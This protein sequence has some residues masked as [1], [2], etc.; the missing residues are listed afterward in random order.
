[1]RRPSRERPSAIAF[2]RGELRWMATGAV[3]LVVLF[4]LISRLRQP[5]A[6]NWFF[7]GKEPSAA[8]SNEERPNEKTPA[9]PAGP[10]DED[11]EEK[12]TFQEDSQAI[13][14]GTL[15]LDRVEM[16]AYDRLVAW[17]QN[18]S[19]AQLDRRAAKGLWYT[20][21]YDSPQ[22]H[23]GRP[24]ALNLDL[25]RARDEGTSRTG[26]RLH[27]VWGRNRESGSRLYD[28]IVVD[29]PKG[30]PEGFDIRVAARFAGYFL[31]LQGYESGK[32]KS[33]RAPLLIGRLEWTPPAAP[34]DSDAAM[35]WIFAAVAVAIVGLVLA[36][37]FVLR[38]RPDA[39]RVSVLTPPAD[40]AAL[41]DRWLEQSANNLD[42]A[43][44]VVDHS[45]SD[46]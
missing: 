9:A 39:D 4:L 20:D 35:E 36:W 12:K 10:T 16:E 33:D 6:L 37:R 46:K 18:Q 30:M 15:T 44:R 23:R 27:E 41:V 11:P 5:G 8:T 13:V 17:V 34:A 28:L 25:Y 14:D 38:R 7:G 40:G 32:D 26:A 24:V 2:R 3:M 19:F 21:F 22:E 1:M 31:K 45:D 29:Y 43:Q 42:E